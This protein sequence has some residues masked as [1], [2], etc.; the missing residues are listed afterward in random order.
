MAVIDAAGGV[1]ALKELS[2]KVQHLSAGPSCFRWPPGMSIPK[3]CKQRLESRKARTGDSSDLVWY[4][5]GECG[6]QLNNIMY[7]LNK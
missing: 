3:P 6:N 2:Q 5:S 4:I 1:D 7:T